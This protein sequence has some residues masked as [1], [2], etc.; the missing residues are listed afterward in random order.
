MLNQTHRL[1]IFTGKGGVGKT[2]LAM[3]FT[4]HLQNAGVNVKYNCFYQNPESIL[5]EK[6]DLPRIDM[7]VEKSAEVYIGKKLNSTTIASWI[8]KTHFFQSLFQMIPGLG[9]M[10]LLGH[11]IEL[12]EKDPSLVIVLDSPASGHALTMFESSTNFKKIFKTGLLVRDIDRMHAFLK[13]PSHLKTHVVTL[14]TELA[15]SEAVDLKFELDNNL[16]DTDAHCN[17]II[18]DSFKRFFD[19]HQVEES[20]LPD[21]LKQKIE[22][23]KNILDGFKTLPHIDRPNTVEIIQELSHLVGELV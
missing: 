5:E 4:K 7:R 16:Q 8:M 17:I 1:Y 6:L 20:L 11:L 15:L 2:S 19:I 21:F 12:L 10:I 9:H 3:A 14:A 22:L 18:N 23:E 13:N